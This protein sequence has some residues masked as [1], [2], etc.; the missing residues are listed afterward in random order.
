MFRRP[1]VGPVIIVT[2]FVAPRIIV[3]V[4]TIIIDCCAHIRNAPV[5]RENNSN[6]T[7]VTR[8]DVRAYILHR[9]RGARIGE[10]GRWI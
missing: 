10:K 5:A 2:I 8:R 1:T 6:Q 4:I 9:L 7:T 3:I